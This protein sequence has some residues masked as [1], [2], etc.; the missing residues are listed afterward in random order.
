MFTILR[1]PALVPVLQEAGHWILCNK[2]QE[3]SLQVVIQI[4][5]Q[6][7]NQSPHHCRGDYTTMILH[8]WGVELSPFMPLKLVIVKKWC[9]TNGITC[10]HHHHKKLK[11][12]PNPLKD[13]SV[14]CNKIWADPSE[15]IPTFRGGQPTPTKVL[16]LNSESLI[17]DISLL[18]LLHS[19]NEPMPR[20]RHRGFHYWI[21]TPGYTLCLC[22]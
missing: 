21:F 10:T 20:S 19:L 11:F 12:D 4:S 17:N 6:T 5:L 2:N 8:C 22:T 3:C 9:V 13:W 18:W 1:V 15:F 14:E 16:A 7:Q